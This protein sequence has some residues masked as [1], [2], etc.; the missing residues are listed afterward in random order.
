MDFGIHIPLKDSNAVTAADVVCNLG[1]EAFVVHQEKLEFPNVADQQL[2]QAIR[3][4]MSRL[5]QNHKLYA[6]SGTVI[7][8]PS[9]CFHIRSS[10]KFSDISA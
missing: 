3:Q 9:C 8:V 7:H 6:C 5:N 10:I 2:L 1:R 4:K